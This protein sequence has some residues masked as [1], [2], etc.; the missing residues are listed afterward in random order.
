SNAKSYEAAIEALT[1]RQ[2]ERS[3][4]MEYLMG[5]P[6]EIDKLYE[7]Y[8]SEWEAQCR[9]AK[10]DIEAGEASVR[11]ASFEVKMLEAVGS[12]SSYFDKAEARKEL[13]V[14][15]SDLAAKKTIDEGCPK[16]WPSRDD[17]AQLMKL[18]SKV[19]EKK[20]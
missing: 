1:A 9:A 15:Q 20:P 16:G 4:Q 12:A 13:V 6:V 11:L 19:A 3:V 14:A 5:A 2:R 10:A 17:L 7:L 18:D 8:V